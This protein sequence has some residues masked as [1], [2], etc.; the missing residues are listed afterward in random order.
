LFSDEMPIMCR[1]SEVK[2]EKEWRASSGLLTQMNS[3]Q[4]VYHRGPF[5]LCISADEL[6]AGCVP[7]R[8]LS[9]H[10]RRMCTTA[11]EKEMR[12]GHGN[13]S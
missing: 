13:R 9:L 3:P 1:Q 10:L 2:Q 12:Q 11:I 4:D 5:F 6:A 8:F 7:P